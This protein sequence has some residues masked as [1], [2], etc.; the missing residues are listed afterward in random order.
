[1]QEVDRRALP[2]MDVQLPSSIQLDRQ[3]YAV[4]SENT[5]GRERRQVDVAPHDAA[6]PCVKCVHCIALHEHDSSWQSLVEGWGAGR[7]CWCEVS[8][9]E[10]QRLNF[11][12]QCQWRAGGRGG[13]ADSSIARL[14][15]L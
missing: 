15:R 3:P 5:R 8:W 7:I 14:V 11:F 4:L 2:I 9:G 6:Q 12:G 10:R 13:E 1:M